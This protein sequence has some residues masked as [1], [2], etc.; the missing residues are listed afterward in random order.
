MLNSASNL[1]NR[2]PTRQVYELNITPKIT[3]WKSRLEVHTKKTFSI[4]IGRRSGWCHD[5]AQALDIN[6]YMTVG[7]TRNGPTGH[8]R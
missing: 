6:S 5:F 3:Y 2:L 7:M 4:F 8:K 1:Q